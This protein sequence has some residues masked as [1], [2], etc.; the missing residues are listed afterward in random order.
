M[1]FVVTVMGSK[2]SSASACFVT[3]DNNSK[4]NHYGGCIYSVGQVLTTILLLSQ[5]CPLGVHVMAQWLTNPTRNHEVAGL[6]PGLTQWVKDPA[7]P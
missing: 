6:I 2:D 5:N 3:L 4:Y 1:H 7:L